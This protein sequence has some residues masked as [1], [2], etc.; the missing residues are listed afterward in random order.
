MQNEETNQDL[1]EKSVDGKREVEGN[2]ERATTDN[3]M[4][5]EDYREF[6]EQQL[7]EYSHSI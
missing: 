5:V 1:G 4:V 7:Q 6:N 3:K 2:E